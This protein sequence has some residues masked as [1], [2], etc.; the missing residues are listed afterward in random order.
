[1][2]SENYELKKNIEITM[3]EKQAAEVERKNH[4]N[5]LAQMEKEY[6]ENIQEMEKK[7]D[8]YIRDVEEE[9]KSEK[10]ELEEKD[11]QI[12]ELTSKLTDQEI[13]NTKVQDIEKELIEK[14]QEINK[15]QNQITKNIGENEST[16]ESLEMELER[17]QNENGVL[18]SG[19]TALE[20]SLEEKKESIQ[21]LELKIKDLNETIE[22]SNKIA[23]DSNALKQEFEVK[24]QNYVEAIADYK[25]QIT[26]VQNEK[27]EL[28]DSF[29]QLNEKILQDKQNLEQKL[30][31][32]KEQVH[33]LL[34][35]L[36]EQQNSQNLISDQLEKSRQTHENNI[37]DFKV[38]I[39]LLENKL[40]SHEFS[41]DEMTTL[42]NAEKS[43]MHDLTTENC[44]LVDQLKNLQEKLQS[45]TEAEVNSDAKIACLE[46]SLNTKT[47]SVQELEL[48]IEHLN[49]TLENA[50]KDVVHI[51]VLQNL[52]NK[53][54]N[55]EEMIENYK[56]EIFLLQS[57]L[58]SH[59]ESYN[60]L[61][62]TLNVEKS[63][64]LKFD[65]HIQS[66][67]KLEQD[68][69][70]KKT[71]C[72]SLQNQITKLTEKLT[73][74]ETERSTLVSSITDLES[75]LKSA[76]DQSNET[77]K[78]NSIQ[79]NLLQKLEMKCKNHEEEI[80]NYKVQ[81]LLLQ[82]KLSS[83]EVS[84]KELTQ[85]LTLT[86][87]SN[88]ELTNSLNDAKL[89]NSQVS[90]TVQSVGTLEKDLASKKS[91]CEFLKSKCDSLKSE[92]NSFEIQ[93]S[94]LTEL[95]LKSE[96]ERSTLVS[97]ITDLESSLKNAE[98]QSNENNKIN[99]IQTS[100]LQNLEI[101]CKNYEEAI[102]NYK[103]HIL[104]LQSKLSSHEESYDELMSLKN[105]E[106]LKIS[107][108]TQLNAVLTRQLNDSQKENQKLTEIQKQKDICQFESQKM[109]DLVKEKDLDICELN[110]TIENLN[111]KLAQVENDL[112]KSIE[113]ANALAFDQ[114]V[115][116]TEISTLMSNLNQQQTEYQNLR[117]DKSKIEEILS[118]KDQELKDANDKCLTLQAQIEELNRKASEI[119][120]NKV[121]D[122][123]LN[124][125]S[126]NVDMY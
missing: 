87:E 82:S 80:E 2:E 56:V 28:E 63:K 98:D 109:Q 1:M 39:V 119:G 112:T 17:V 55:Y 33:S 88:E 101:K 57:K 107:E 76:K 20:T 95:L 23:E 35:Q 114:N 58:S 7:I 110:L 37:E 70:S 78:K 6:H 89:K 65:E 96:T 40:A 43:K 94:E 49:E 103:V 68:L 122:F 9:E 73:K 124:H 86:Q 62:A 60:E 46:N 51:N 115:K 13:L 22:E 61:V 19:F 26:H 105:V 21:K 93:I 113:Q 100:V 106:N 53:C 66:I 24:C 67:D 48:K 108:I 47:A 36:S 45:L 99:V 90:E 16:I 52:E 83:H 3:I 117:V 116:E 54:Q 91:Q 44:K 121:C 15:L 120:K 25:V 118:N 69:A 79:T 4:E 42:L 71:E 27:S 59:E 77:K 30:E 29:A 11:V 123:Y 5:K 81:I 104:L 72:E 126:L 64:T 97:T 12:Q 85:I 18:G 111:T 102:E 31:E 125:K 38:Q 74:T 41:F 92:C 8:G 34:E 75:S 10:K 14:N 32:T 84:Y 50:K